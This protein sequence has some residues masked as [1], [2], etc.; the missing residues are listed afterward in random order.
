MGSQLERIKKASE[1]QKKAIYAL[2]PEDAGSHLE[3]IEKEISEMLIQGFMEMIKPEE[4][5]MAAQKTA[6]G[7][8]AMKK[9]DIS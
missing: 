6:A 3:I 5:K 4:E 7:K 2:F 8:S 1:Y 9:V